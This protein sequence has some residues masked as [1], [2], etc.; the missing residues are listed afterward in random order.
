MKERS[1]RRV[2]LQI[3]AVGAEGTTAMLHIFGVFRHGLHVVDALRTNTLADGAHM[4]RCWNTSSGVVLL[5][6]INAA[7][8]KLLCDANQKG[9]S[10]D[11]WET[12]FGGGLLG[13]KTQTR[14]HLLRGQK[15][16]AS[17]G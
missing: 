7:F 11:V 4:G 3:Q 14:V 5:Q 9:L 16:E 13:M 12:P 15:G 2:K 10:D 6:G 8:Q 1:T 17:K